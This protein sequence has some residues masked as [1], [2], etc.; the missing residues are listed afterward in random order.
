MRAVQTMVIAMMLCACSGLTLMAQQAPQQ[1]RVQGQNMAKPQYRDLPAPDRSRNGG[2]SL[3]KLNRFKLLSPQEVLTD[4]FNAVDKLWLQDGYEQAVALDF[5]ADVEAQLPVPRTTR[6]VSGEGSLDMDFRVEGVSAPNGSYRMD[7]EGGFGALQLINDGRRFLLASE[8]F[9]SYADRP[10]RKRNENANLNNYRSYMRRYLGKMRSDIMDSGRWRM[11]YL[12]EGESEG[13]GVHV[14]R[15]Y[16]PTGTLRTNKKAPVSL[17]KMWTFWQE[18]AYEIW[19][20]K[21]VKLPMVVFYSNPEDNIFANFRFDYDSDWL[22]QRISYVNNSTGASGRGDV[23]M[24]FDDARLLTG[25]SLKYDGDNGISLNLNATLD[26]LEAVE[27]DAFRVIPPFGHRK[28]NMDH[29]KLMV[30]TQISG[31]LLKLKR[32]GINLKNFKF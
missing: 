26:F 18:G 8:D 29:L 10:I 30:M 11:V 16:Q 24:S 25:L 23:V 28:I 13:H 1:E 5:R 12:G 17:D 9:K 32:H 21:Q 27:A 19:I 22:P 4:M 6:N 14:V 20:H 7:V 31:H 3:N 15:V 2:P